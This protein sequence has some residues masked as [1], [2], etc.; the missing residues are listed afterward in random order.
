MRAA[1]S[2]LAASRY[3][4]AE[5][6][7]L[8]AEVKARKESDER[9]LARILNNLGA[10]RLYQQDYRGAYEALQEARQLCRQQGMAEAEAS[11]WSN[12]ATLYWMLSAWP[13]ADQALDQA[14]KQ[15]P[16]GSRFR[17]AVLAQRVRLAARRPDLKPDEFAR[18]WSEAMEWAENQGDWAVQR[19]LWDE[20]SLYQLEA[21]RLELAET[22][23]AN[24]FRLAVLHRLPDPESLWLLAGQ[25]RLAQQR[26][27]EALAWL[28]RL[29]A[30]GSAQQNPVN[31]LRLAALEARA[32][33]AVHG[34]E[35]ALAACRS[36]WPR[37][38]GWRYAVLPDP[39]V[40]L[41]ADVAMTEFVGEYVNQALAARAGRGPGVEA[42]A[43][44]EQSR[45]LGMLR[46]KQRRKKAG[47]S[48]FPAGRPV[49]VLTAWPRSGGIADRGFRPI[50]P[51]DAPAEGLAPMAPQTLLRMVQKELGQDQALFTFWLGAG[52][53]FLW[54]V[55]RDS[56]S[57]A[58]LPARDR[59]IQEFH[60][61]RQQ[62]E[63]GGQGEV[64][65]ELFRATFGRAP[66]SARQRRQW[67]ISADEE[68]LTVP[69]AAFRLPDPSARYLGQAR[70]LSFL[71]SALWLLEPEVHRPPRNLLAVGGLVHNGADHRWQAPESSTATAPGPGEG[72]RTLARRAVPPDP[73]YELPSLPGSA[74]EVE[75]IAN[76]W[77]RRGLT[78]T[79]LEGFLATES[80]IHD[81]LEQGWT[82]LHFATHVRPAPAPRAY[83]FVPEPPGAAAPLLIRFPAGETFLALSLRRDGVREGLTERDL[84]ALRLDGA[85]V[86]LNGC[87]TGVGPAQRGAGL[88]SFASAWL[89]AGAQSVVAS[90]WSIDDDGTFFESY[91]A[92]LLNGARPAAALQAAQSAMIGSGTWRSQPRYWAA[93][94]HLGK[95]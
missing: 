1:A 14:L 11:V 70:A 34:P 24:S 63:N 91:Y 61:F 41:A 16:A 74:R 4:E 56:L 20:L 13:A 80:S 8:C 44:V 48:G 82:D 50:S 86:V 62:V 17:P 12:L 66:E 93:Y 33:A 23:L 75:A 32:E 85:R 27:V 88:S 19:H 36:H 42:W 26:P 92:A 95:D 60:R 87:S 39:V 5:L 58:V 38:L 69:L 49:N 77:S 31:L 83:R 6:L 3:G 43:V 68:P 72:S 67:L 21:G 45:A 94:I 9:L 55:T 71:P 59:L 89:A 40:E 78:A 64:G 47:S 37:V 18:L 35:A 53:S 2:L 84:A 73:D 79:R 76:L 57:T 25:L 52:R 54:A 46:T 22:A 29:R 81:A 30:K 7:S 90:L 15:M 65:G 51:F 10:A 28:G